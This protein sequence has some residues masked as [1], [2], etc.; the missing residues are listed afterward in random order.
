[1]YNSLTGC[2]INSSQEDIQYYFKKLDRKND[3]IIDLEEYKEAM[4]ANH[5]LYEWFEFANRG[6]ADENPVTEIDFFTFQKSLKTIDKEILDC[7]DLLTGDQRTSRLYCD[8]SG[9]FSFVSNNKS[10]IVD[11]FDILENRP[12]Y[13]NGDDDIPEE[14]FLDDDSKA[15]VSTVQSKL[16]AILNS[17][18]NLMDEEKGIKNKIVKQLD[19]NKFVYVDNNESSEEE[20]ENSFE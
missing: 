14:F 16:A 1:M 9:P 18:Q 5:N 8:K 12:L 13:N 10:D 15:F 3:G 4:M 17:V 2:E 19:I 11:D 6:V 20:N 7:L